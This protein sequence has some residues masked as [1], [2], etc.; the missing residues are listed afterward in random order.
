MSRA[1]V[2]TEEK[3]EEE[4]EKGRGRQST[5]QTPA[6]ARWLANYKKKKIHPSPALKQE[7]R[8]MRRRTKKGWMRRKGR[9]RRRGETV[10]G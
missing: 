6:E 3:E 10:E 9:W 1:V 7:T 5:R 8:Q 2:G 4:E